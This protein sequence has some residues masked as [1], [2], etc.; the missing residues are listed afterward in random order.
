MSNDQNLEV[1]LLV[2]GCQGVGE[3][4]QLERSRVNP[5]D[6]D[7]H[8]L[9]LQMFGLHIIADWTEEVMNSIWEIL[10]VISRWSCSVGIWYDR[11]Q[12]HVNLLT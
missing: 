2:L 3:N 6:P 5:R 12:I 10:T 4:D 8:Y 1:Y 9:E 11:S 7:R